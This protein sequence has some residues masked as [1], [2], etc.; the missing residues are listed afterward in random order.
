LSFPRDFQRKKIYDSEK[1]LSV[2]SENGKMSL[3]EINDYLSRIFK[4]IWLKNAHPTVEGFKIHDGRGRK[5]AAGTAVGYICHLWLPKW[6]R[7]ELV[8]LHELAHGLTVIR[9]GYGEKPWHG[10]EYAWIYLCLVERWLGHSIGN[11]LRHFYTKHHV[12]CRG[13]KDLRERTFNFAEYLNNE[14]ENT[15]YLYKEK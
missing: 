12:K 2:Y 7:S 1:E 15:S 11:E 13:I 4:S 3:Q 10:E 5:G 14:I 9:Y 6:S 8:V